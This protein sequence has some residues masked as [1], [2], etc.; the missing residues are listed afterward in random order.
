MGFKM[1]P[2]V[3]TNYLFGSSGSDLASKGSLT[4]DIL[5]LKRKL[6]KEQF[7]ILRQEAFLMI[8]QAVQQGVDNTGNTAVSGAMFRKALN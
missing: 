3:V 4:R 8:N 7:D 2:E 1:A 5:T 6:P